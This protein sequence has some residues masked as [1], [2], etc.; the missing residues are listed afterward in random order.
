MIVVCFVFSKALNDFQN[1]SLQTDLPSTMLDGKIRRT[2]AQGNWLGLNPL[3][4][5]GP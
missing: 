5:P 3:E 1:L 4:V 2:A